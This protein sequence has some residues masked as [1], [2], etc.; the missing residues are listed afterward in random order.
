[1]ARCMR[2]AIRNDAA[3]ASSEQTGG[4]HPADAEPVVDVVQVALDVERADRVLAEQHRFDR[5]E[6]VPAEP[7]QRLAAA[8]GQ[9]PGP[10]RGDRWRTARP[11]PH[12]G[13]PSGCAGG[14]RRTASVSP[15]AWSSLER[16]RRRAVLGDDP[17]C[18][19]TSLGDLRAKLHDIPR[20]QAAAGERERRGGRGK[21]HQQQLVANRADRG[22]ASYAAWIPRQP[23]Q[24]RADAQARRARRP[25]RRSRTA[26]CRPRGRS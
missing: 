15:A 12:T 6:R 13:R 20:E 19:S 9:A 18:A 8:T 22:T 1:M 24:A 7:R 5:L 4:G 2:R 21:R 11:S 3:M 25:R 16:Q 17:A 14:A 10:R 26:R 23:Q